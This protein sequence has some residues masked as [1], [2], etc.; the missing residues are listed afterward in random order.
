MEN[1]NI[2]FLFKKRPHH[3]FSNFIFALSYWILFI[4][5]NF[6]VFHLN[7]KYS[8]IVSLKISITFFPLI[9]LNIMY[10]VALIYFIFQNLRF[11]LGRV[12]GRV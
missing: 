2:K 6:K 10:R 3:I 8:K 11:K 1:Y 4:F 9:P 5:S 12:I 7:L